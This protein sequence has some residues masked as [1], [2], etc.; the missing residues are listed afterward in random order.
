MLVNL[1]IHSY[2][3]FLS[4]FVGYHQFPLLTS[5]T[6]TKV[7]YIVIYTRQVRLLDIDSPKQVRWFLFQYF[8]NYLLFH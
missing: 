7:F 8:L 2:Q 6:F 1:L 3:F 5:H 4:L